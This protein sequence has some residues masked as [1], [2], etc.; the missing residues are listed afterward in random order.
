MTC[1]LKNPKMCGPTPRILKFPRLRKSELKWR[2]C[3]L[4]CSRCLWFA[5]LHNF[6]ALDLWPHWLG[7]LEFPMHLAS[8]KLERLLLLKA[9]CSYFELLQVFHSQALHLSKAT[10][11]I[12]PPPLVLLCFQSAC[13]LM[14]ELPAPLACWSHSPPCLSLRV[15]PT[16]GSPLVAIWRFGGAI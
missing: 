11:C 13:S 2:S 12:R 3:L 16:L 7:I 6:T 10:A 1:N 8:V 5:A 9:P 4:F 14:S 15:V